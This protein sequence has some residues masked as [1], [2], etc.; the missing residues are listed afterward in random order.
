MDYWAKYLSRKRFGK[1]QEDPEADQSGRNSFARD[2][3]RVVFSTP[4]RRLQNKTQVVPLPEK[5]FIHT[6]LTH[7]LEASCI[8]RSLGRNVGQLII[9]MDPDFFRS[10]QISEWD[11][12]SL[13]AAAC[14]VHDIGNPPFGH[15]G[16]KAISEFFAAGP[17][18]VLI[19]DLPLELQSDFRNFEGNAMGFRLLTSAPPAQTQISGGL[20]LTYGTLGAFTKYPREAGGP[21]PGE[22]ASS[23][24]YGFFQA[25]KRPFQSV[26]NE[27]GLRKKEKTDF[28]GWY[29]HPL[30]Y[31]VEAADDICYLVIDLEDGYK[32]GS[33]S[34]DEIRFCYDNVLGKK[35]LKKVSRK[36]DKI[37][38]NHEK[39]GY[40]R[41]K[42]I[43]KLIS[44]TCS[45]YINNL[46]SILSGQFD[47]E[48]KKE[49]PEWPALENIFDLS[50]KKVYQAE[51]IM[52]VEA[53]GYEVIHGLLD[54][55]SSALEGN[56]SQDA[57]IRQLIPDQYLDVGRELFPDKY[58]RLLN[59][60]QYVAGM[61]DGHALELYRKFKGVSL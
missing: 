54:I 8:G 38:D 27:L 19:N 30:A 7:S 56:T 50:R 32:R 29:R 53:A 20:G 26:A 2:F 61:T 28:L 44:S 12:E 60:V 58:I 22:G 37:L 33:V 15:S 14:L 39:I 55:Y 3:D 49:I 5:D 51:D 1:E 59:I 34:F 11:F 40:L 41:A 9:E 24:K 57:R 35:D 48:L 17:G 25:E 23:K 21:I 46:E 36:I 47:R 4:F 6:R 16:E 43:S 42:V 18:S 31:L 45:I 13:V 52:E 10:I